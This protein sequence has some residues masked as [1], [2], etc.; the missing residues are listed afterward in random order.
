MTFASSG[1][2]SSDHLSIALFWQLTGSNGIHVPYKGGGPAIADLVAGHAEASFQNLN[3][4]TSHVKAGKLKALAVTGEKRSPL[5]P[6]VPT[7]VELGYKDMV[8]YS[9]QALGAP[10]GLSADVK[11]AIHGAMI[12]AL[13]DPETAKKLTDPG[14]EIVASTPEEFSAFLNSE[15]AR[16]KSVIEVGKITLD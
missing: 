1:A 11:K 16:W 10:K 8:V 6:D 15:L 4:M 3:V 14:F 2:G 5:L 12:A 13:K 7:L 9:W